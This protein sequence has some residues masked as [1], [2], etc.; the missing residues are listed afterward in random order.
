MTGTEVKL[1]SQPLWGNIMRL[2]FRLITLMGLALSL[3]QSAFSQIPAAPQTLAPQKVISVVTADWNDDG[4]VDRAV[5]YE[6]AEDADLLIYLSDPATGDGP[7]LNTFRPG[8]AW[9]GHMWGTL[10]SLKLGAKGS[11]QLMSENTGV[12]RDKWQQTLTLVYR[13]KTFVVGGVTYSAYDSLDPKNA[14]S[15]DVNLL[16][17]KAVRDKKVVK[18]APQT[19]AL[20]DWRD[21][22]LPA[23]C[24]F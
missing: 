20:T 15:C 16:T 6:G 13:N 19:I 21:D 1:G 7:R 4:G 17:G 11:L 5:L 8:A 14:H 18:M 10:P 12:G 22:K 24:K 23:P 3:P 9:S 2:N